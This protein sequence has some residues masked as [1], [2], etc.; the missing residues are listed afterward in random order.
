LYE[1][2]ASQGHFAM[3]RTPDWWARRLW[4][5]PGEWL[6]VEGRRRGQIEGYLQ[7][8]VDNANGPFKLVLSIHEMI[9]ATPEAHR[10]LAG[11]LASL[12]DQ[13]SEIHFAAPADHAWHQVMRTAQNLHPGVEISVL[14]DMGNV[15]AGLMLRLT[16]V[17]A[18]LEALPVA[19][20]ARGEVVLEVR[21]EILPANARGWR[22]TARDGRLTVVP[23]P[24][25]G[26]SRRRARV[27]LAADVLGPVVAG[28]L[29]P[30]RAAEVGLLESSGGG[31]EVIERWF[32]ARPAFVHYFNMF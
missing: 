25:T 28:T 10:G 24:A 14:S 4:A 18:G 9:A 29:L 30:V 26:A 27:M 13:V 6:V 22:V 17:K 23:E 16:D 21:D 15:A 32:R 5:Y 12:A 3:V 2:V 8:E 11:Y 1:K 31:A 20:S 7:Y 19:P